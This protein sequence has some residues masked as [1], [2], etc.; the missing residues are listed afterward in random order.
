M[1]R[2]TEAVNATES[3]AMTEVATSSTQAEEGNR[4]DGAICS[5]FHQQTFLGG[6]LFKVWSRIASKSSGRLL[7]FEFAENARAHE[8]SGRK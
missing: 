4:G 7:K 5:P 6:E 1:D 3:H 2:T 8:I